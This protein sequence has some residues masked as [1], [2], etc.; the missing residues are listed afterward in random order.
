MA[1]HTIGRRWLATLAGPGADRPRAPAADRHPKRPGSRVVTARGP[2]ALPLPTPKGATHVPALR[3][4]RRRLGRRR[5]ARRRRARLVSC[6][7]GGRTRDRRRDPCDR[8]QRNDRDHDSRECNE[9]SRHGAGGWIHVR[10]DGTGAA[11]HRALQAVKSRTV[12]SRQRRMTPAS[13]KASG[14]RPLLTAARP[15]SQALPGV[16][17]QPTAAPPP[18]CRRGSSRSR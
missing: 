17:D 13:P 9:P 3:A 12:L 11:R 15:A 18:A 10:K 6:T 1:G 8:E 7:R 16:S 2:G 14:G 4:R 5:R